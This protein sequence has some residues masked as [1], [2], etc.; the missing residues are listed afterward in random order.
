MF[1]ER[2]DMEGI[3]HDFEIITLYV[4]HTLLNSLPF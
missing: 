3:D 2:K 1:H 4:K